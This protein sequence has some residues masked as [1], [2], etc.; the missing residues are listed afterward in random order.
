MN[1]KNQI[2]QT[3][4]IAGTLDI[5]AACLNAYISNGV[6]PDRVL[7][8]IASGAFGKD[9]YSGGYDMM[10]LG[11]LFHFMIAFACTICYFWLY[12]KL[13][14]L[15]KNILL[16]AV[17]V[18]IVAWVVTTRMVIPMSQI[19]P[20]PFNLVKA[21]TAVSILIVCIGLPIAYFA[22]KFYKN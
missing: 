17:L 18:G 20:P 1:I 7:K 8:Y 2:L 19:T 4:L 9:A 21:L 14:F 3:G 13:S 16:S 15:H 5:T 11:L 12:P 10:T 6:T 22:D